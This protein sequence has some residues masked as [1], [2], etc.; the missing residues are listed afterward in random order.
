M[1]GKYKKVRLYSWNRH[2]IDK[3]QQGT[4][5]SGRS[6][7]QCRT[8]ILDMIRSYVAHLSEFFSL[9]DMA[10]SAANSK[11]SPLPKFLPI[12]TDSLTTSHHLIRILSEITECINELLSM[13]VSGDTN[14]GLRALLETATWKFEET[15]CAT[16]LRGGY[17][18]EPEV[19]TEPSR[20]SSILSLGDLG[21]KTRGSFDHSLPREDARVSKVHYDSRLQDSKW[22]DR[23]K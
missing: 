8:M 14:S 13:D 2:N 6:P 5:P 19:L 17:R 23:L 18:Q 7:S 1:E 22:Y 20:F 21:A 9:S 3:E 4:Q 16:W 11:N 12:G 15:L 10:A